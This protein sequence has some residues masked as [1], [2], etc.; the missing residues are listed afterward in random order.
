[1]THNQQTVLCDFLTVFG[2]T[3]E[4]SSG[5]SEQNQDTVLCEVLP[6]LEQTLEE[7]SGL[8]DTESIDGSV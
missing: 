8:S 4:I 7:S 3:T 5:Y 6:H 1:M 2:Q